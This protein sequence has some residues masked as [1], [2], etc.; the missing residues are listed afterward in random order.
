MCST[1][2]FSTMF[3]TTPIRTSTV[4]TR[5]LEAGRVLA[6]F[7]TC[8]LDAPSQIPALIFRFTL[9]GLLTINWAIFTD[10][11]QMK[12]YLMRKKLE[13]MRTARG[14]SLAMDRDYSSLKFFISPFGLLIPIILVMDMLLGGLC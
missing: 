2:K 12:R 10:F 13:L 7:Q 3:C 4:M 11:Q 1:G 9:Y 8:R 14:P 6:L 5:I